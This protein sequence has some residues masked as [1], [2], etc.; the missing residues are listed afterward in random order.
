MPIKDI[1]FF[2]ESANQYRIYLKIIENISD[3]LNITICYM[4]WG[5]TVK[6][7][8][9][10]EISIYPPPNGVVV[11]D[12]LQS[13]N[14]IYKAAI[15]SAANKFA[16]LTD[17]SAAY[18]SIFPRAP[19]VVMG[20][21]SSM[22][23]RGMARAARNM[24][25]PHVLIQDG[26][27]SFKSKSNTLQNVDQ[28]YNWGSSQPHLAFAWGDSIKE[29]TIERHK[30]N[31]HSIITTGPVKDLSAKLFDEYISQTARSDRAR[32]LW[33]DQAILDQNKAP[34]DH[35]LLEHE[36]IADLLSKFDTTIRFHPSSDKKNI[37]ALTAQC[38][39]Y[40]IIDPDADKPLNHHS[41]SAYDF[42]F[43][44]YSTA[45]LDAL[46]AGK[47]CIIYKTRA[48]EIELPDIV[49]SRILYAD[50]YE[51]LECLIS[52]IEQNRDLQV[53]TR[54]KG[55]KLDYFIHNTETAERRI[56]NHILSLCEKFSP[57]EVNF[58]SR[59]VS[60]ELL[61]LQESRPE[62]LILGGTFGDHIGAGIP[63]RMV[64][65]T[66]NRLGV[67]VTHHLTTSGSKQVFMSIL[68]TARMV[69][70]NSMEF[71]KEARLDCL[72]EAVNYLKSN[73]I[74]CLLYIHETEYVYNTLMEKH[75]KNLDFMKQHYLPNFK[76]A[77]VSESQ[78]R[79]LQSQGAK[80]T[81]VVNNASFSQ[82]IISRTDIANLRR[83]KE[84]NPA[85]PFRVIMAGT[86]QPRKGIELFSR[87]A[88]IA[89]QRSSNME[90]VWYGQDIKAFESHYRSPNV[91]YIPHISGE[92]MISAM[93]DADVFFLSSI[94]DP[95]PLSAVEAI[96]AGVP[97][98]CFKNT[99]VSEIIEVAEN[100]C[101]F[102]TYTPKMAYQA[103]R[104]VQLSYDSYHEGCDV[105]RMILDPM[106]FIDKMLREIYALSLNC[107]PSLRNNRETFSVLRGSPP[108]P[109]SSAPLKPQKDVHIKPI[110]RSLK[111]LKEKRYLL[112]YQISSH[113]LKKT[114]TSTKHLEVCRESATILG[115]LYQKKLSDLMSKLG[116]Y[117]SG[118]N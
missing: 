100:G 5:H 73:E 28:N 38:A 62:I 55:L 51:Q 56:A 108:I 113:A 53:Y 19:L 114:P 40:V 112:A 65:E 69:I 49:H 59:I 86:Q 67:P 118:Q 29:E 90:F 105:A 71:F 43:T 30:N 11:T 110:E 81:V 98:V 97:I 76:V 95:F 36:Y 10:D 12:I 33:I 77:C 2:C 107:R 23:G 50:T 84:L 88:D 37:E 74:P 52:D 8:I 70:I 41:F 9:E 82:E 64:S 1:I 109:R 27:L 58:H 13:L 22:R 78:A 111:A 103:L 101:I 20:N 16:S 91:T 63:I 21:D 80:H 116:I 46:A 14:D 106:L 25:I 39:S 4:D 18:L 57:Q 60:Q 48:L 44:Y 6:N 99:G 45:F 31:P 17:A 102:S 92:R 94:D 72:E 85:R 115:D 117:P 104:V 89:M 35:W 42:V 79:F 93:E 47:Y 68:R 87:V 61:K 96:S 66:L 26:F 24:A 7:W 75:H 3:Q 34:R 54:K 32:I 83:S 15:G